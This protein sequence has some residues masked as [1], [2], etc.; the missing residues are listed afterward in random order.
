MGLCGVTGQQW[1]AERRGSRGRSCQALTV[2]CVKLVIISSLKPCPVSV[3]PSR[4]GEATDGTLKQDVSV[5]EVNL[6]RDGVANIM[7]GFIDTDCS[8]TSR[9]GPIN[10]RAGG[11]V[12][13]AREGAAALQHGDKCL[14][15]LLYGRSGGPGARDAA[16][17]SRGLKD[18]GQFILHP[19]RRELAAVLNVSE[20]DAQTQPQMPRRD[21]SQLQTALFAQS[22]RFEQF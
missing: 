17:L 14:F 3:R 18:G 6:R 13:G 8:D 11:G 22:C 4:P 20:R 9:S 15:D 2:H 16:A 7:A 5:R 10:L 21:R 19:A 12:T 1:M